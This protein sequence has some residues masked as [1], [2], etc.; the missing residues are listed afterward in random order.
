MPWS[1]KGAKG[2]KGVKGDFGAASVVSG[3]GIAQPI[4]VVQPT[5]QVARD[6]V[7]DEIGRAHV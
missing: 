3:Q 6:Q 4:Q 7:W 2:A 1:K 5:V